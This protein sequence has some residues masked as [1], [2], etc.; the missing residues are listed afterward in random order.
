MDDNILDREFYAEGAVAVARKLLGK[1]L[2]HRSPE[3]ETSGMI[4]ETEAYAGREDAACHSYKKTSPSRGHRT[5]VMF[6]PGGYAYVYLI[7]GMHHCF[8]V[9]ANGP[10][11]PEAVLVRALE[12]LRGAELMRA[13][14]RVSK[15]KDL[16]GGPG[17]LC[18]AFGITLK[19]YGIDLCGNEIFITRGGDVPDRDTLSTRRINVDYAG[20]ASGYPYRF[21]IRGSGFL[22]T[23]RYVI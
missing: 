14:R 8:N 13:R 6:G 20:E 2:V 7:Y 9:V 1:I 3:G 16:C 23:R 15:L 18:R 5:N 4:T 21:V 12:P 22:S 17:K 19:D 10:G 11:F